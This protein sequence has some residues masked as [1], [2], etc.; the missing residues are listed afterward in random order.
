MQRALK[1]DLNRS[2]STHT[3]LRQ[4]ARAANGKREMGSLVGEQEAV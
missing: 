2:V 4:G 3:S 1:A